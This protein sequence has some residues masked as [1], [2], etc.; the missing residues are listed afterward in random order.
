M[1]SFSRTRER[2]FCISQYGH[3]A[4]LQVSI[5]SRI[6]SLTESELK[7]LEVA[8]RAFPLIDIESIVYMGMK[9]PQALKHLAYY[10]NKAED[11]KA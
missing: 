4:L 7:R 6:V 9:R 10:E 1:G 2:V 11:L 5:R 8:Q 3:L